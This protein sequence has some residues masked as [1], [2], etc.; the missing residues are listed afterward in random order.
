M[1]TSQRLIDIKSIVENSYRAG[2]AQAIEDL[3]S[4]IINNMHV[5]ISAKMLNELLN[6][7]KLQKVTVKTD[8]NKSFGEKILNILKYKGISQRELSEKVG[9]T[10]V[11]ISRYISGE[12]VPKGTIVVKIANALGVSTDYLLDKKYESEER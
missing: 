1:E 2:Y 7:M 5:D 11:S 12:R 6:D 10:E 4:E 9:C 8:C 3:K